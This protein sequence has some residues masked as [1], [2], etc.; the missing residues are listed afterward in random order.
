MHCFMLIKA[1]K[2]RAH[3][4]KLVIPSDGG[5]HAKTLLGSHNVNRTENIVPFHVDL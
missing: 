5:R 3:F 2:Q 1:P 4:Q